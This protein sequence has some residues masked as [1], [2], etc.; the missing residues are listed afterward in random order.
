MIGSD[1][2]SQEELGSSL[3]IVYHVLNNQ[4]KT[5]AQ[6]RCAWDVS[7]LL[8]CS[9]FLRKYFRNMTENQLQRATEVA[10]K[11]GDFVSEQTVDAKQKEQ[12]TDKQV[13]ERATERV[14]GHDIPFEYSPIGFLEDDSSELDSV[15]GLTLIDP[16]SSTSAAV[17]AANALPV[18]AHWLEERCME[19]VLR[20]KSCPFSPQELSQQLLEFLG[21]ARDTLLLQNEL[22]NLLG[23]EAFDF[24]S[25]LIQKRV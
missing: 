15:S 1:I 4:D 21:S 19:Y 16:S 8:I 25:M 13:V 24:I 22:V 5:D 20:V 6:K 23:V 17:Q 12:L 11:L 10:M 9:S 14:F 18:D 2:V 3:Y 7:G